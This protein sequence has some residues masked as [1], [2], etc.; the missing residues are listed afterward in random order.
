MKKSNLLLALLCIALVATIVGESAFSSNSTIWYKDNPITIDAEDAYDYSVLTETVKQTEPSERKELLKVPEITLINMSTEGLIVTCLDYPLFGN[1]VFYDSLSLG[2]DAIVSQY[3][4]LQNLLERSDSGEKL[5]DFY[6][7][8][9][10]NTLLNSDKYNSLRLKYL[11]LLLSDERILNSMSYEKRETLLNCTIENCIKF[12]SEF[13]GAF[14]PNTTARLAGKILYIDNSD[15]QEL[16]DSELTVK[17]F[18]NGEG[19]GEI[20]EEL[21]NEIVSIICPYVDDNI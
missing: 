2:F 15:F 9:D 7:A 13:Q 8:I 14:N 6:I 16:A 3:N 17:A 1:I 21:W 20:S 10:F 12:N 11:E 4:G 18:L 19:V 5:A